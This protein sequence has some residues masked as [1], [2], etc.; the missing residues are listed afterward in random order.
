V[1]LVVNKMDL[2]DFS[3]D[4][5]NRIDADYRLFAEQL[6]LPAI[7]VIPI[8]SVD[9]DNVTTPS[10]RTPWYKGPSLMELLD[11]IE[12]DESRLLSAPLRFPVQWVNRPHLDFRGFAGTLVA[13]SVSRGE[14][15]RVLPSGRS[16]TVARI[17]T[18]DGELERAEIGQSVTLT[19]SD[20]IDVSRG[21]MIVSADSPAEVSDAF[22]GTLV[23]MSE[24]PLLPGRT[25][26]MK[27]GTKTVTATIVPLKYKI[28]VN[29][30]E[31][32]AAAKLDLNEI[33]VVNLQLDRPIA[34]DP[35]KEIRDTGGF[36][37][38]DKISND[39]VGAGM[40]HFALRRAQNVHWQ[41]VDVNKSARAVIKGQ[42]PCVLWYTGLSGAG[43]STIANLVDK[44]LHSMS[45]HGYLL[46]GDNV[47][48]GLNKDLGFTAA[49]R[50]IDR[51]TPSP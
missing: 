16:S 41:A 49:D 6:S 14:T 12:V 48:H 21:D 18:A 22:E 34:F 1:V 33:G 29:T 43:K 31:R 2:V 17:I 42:K 44:R 23:W 9:G 27:I 5:F 30:L 38:I 47:R 36:I 15:I 40:L 8:C 28:N 20:E 25:Y 10:E 45:R 4:V 46:D 11:S 13:G 32:V 51:R 7:T 26:L 19:L 35:Y 39:T 37:L 3:E 24:A 50:I